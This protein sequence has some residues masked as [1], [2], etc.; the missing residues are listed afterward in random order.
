M[1]VIGKFFVK[2]GMIEVPPG[3]KG[4]FLL[5]S[6]KNGSFIYHPLKPTSSN[7]L[8]FEVYDESGG[9]VSFPAEAKAIEYKLAM[10][11][12]RGHSFRMRK[13]FSSAGK[14]GKIV[15]GV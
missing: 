13:V 5:E 7:D 2:K 12:S 9:S 11:K 4:E 1:E 6:N 8:A 15:D 10:E 14:N 3:I